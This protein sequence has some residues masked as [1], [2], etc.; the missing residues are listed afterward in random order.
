MNEQNNN[1]QPQQDQQQPYQSEGFDT[2][3]RAESVPPYQPYQSETQSLEPNQAEAQQPAQTYQPYQN[4]LQPNQTYQ[5]HPVPPKK[6]SMWWIWLIVAGVIV[7]AGVALL[8]FSDIGASL[9]GEQRPGN[10]AAWKAYD[11]F[12]S[13]E[14][15]LNM[16]KGEIHTEFSNRIDTEPFEAK[17]EFELKSDLMK[18]IG[19]GI[20]S[21]K[22][23][24]AA[25]YDL[26]DL[27]V[28]L[29]LMGLLGADIYLIEDQWVINVMGEAYAMEVEANDDVDLQEDMT[30][31]DRMEA[32]NSVS[33][34]NIKELLE[35]IMGELA[36][37]IPNELTETETAD[38][39][40][41]LEDDEVEMK[42]YTTTLD[43]D[44]FQQLIVTFGENLE[45]NEDLLDDMQDFLDTIFKTSGEKIDVDDMVEDMIDFDET[46]TDDQKYTFAYSVY[47]Y[48][49]KTVGIS[50]SFEDD[51]S[52]EFE[53]FIITE[54][55]DNAVYTSIIAEFERDEIINFNSVVEYSEGN[56]DT[57]AVFTITMPENEYSESQAV[58]FSIKGSTTVDKQNNTEYEF[59]GDY[60]IALDSGSLLSS[61]E[62]DKIEFDFGFEGECEF[63]NDLGTLKEDEDWNKIYDEEW[64]DL[65]DLM[66]T[67]FSMSG[68]DN[69]DMGSIGDV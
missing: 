32:F 31:K 68:M 20:E 47:E 58:N 4:E 33:T 30:L 10:Q 7:I 14:D 42:A 19:Y 40:S 62:Q 18:E 9:F 44:D 21:F 67:I 59:S 29:D 43:Q 54:F 28:Q 38:V 52:N 26:K 56:V 34:A 1:D 35:R 37:A 6:K 53:M 5:D 25:K 23:D 15:N 50:F 55:S 61:L 27:G 63:S 46:M 13:M 3:P 69:L 8:L 22:S 36:P 41:P 39:Y 2:V 48:K 60:K 51:S 24:F 11:Y 57:D 64:G 45:Q 16:I 17:G 12:N 65:E 66:R 49:G